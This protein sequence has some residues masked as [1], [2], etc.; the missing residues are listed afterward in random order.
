MRAIEAVEV[1]TPVR[2]I[3]Y[4]GAVHRPTLALLSLLA[5]ISGLAACSSETTAQHQN[6][7]MG[8]WGGSGG[9]GG[10]GGTAAAGGFGAY[11]AGGVGGQGATG[12]GGSQ[13]VDIGIGEANQ[14]EQTA[15]SLSIAPISDCDGDGGVISGTVAGP[16]DV[17]WF[18][19]RGD[20][21]GTCSVDPYVF[22]D[23][24]DP[25]VRICVFLEC[26]AGAT[27]LTACPQGSDTS[28]S[29]GGRQ[30]CCST[31]GFDIAD[32]FNCSGSMD[33]D[34]YVYMRIDHPQAPP[35]ICDSYVLSYHY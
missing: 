6:P 23:T 27:E 10:A 2:T 30:G 11:G 25:G 3:G 21:T 35:E 8:P 18:T 34:A 12:A 1:L 4:H 31:S 29:P 33:D 14:T 26:V 24:A 7:T 17:D 13:C 32:N 9:T 15:F 22:F 28:V 19:Y 16:S 5:A 20:D